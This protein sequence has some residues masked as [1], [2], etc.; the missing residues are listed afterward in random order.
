M[1]VRGAL[2]ERATRVVAEHEPHAGRVPAVEVRRHG[3]VGVAPQ[4]HVVVAGAPAERDRVVES[5]GRSLMRGPVAAAVDDEERFA[6]VGQRDQERVVSPDPLEREVH[7]RLA[8]AERG[9]DRAVGVDARGLGREVT[10]APRPDGD[11]RLVDDA[12]EPPDRVGVEPAAEVA[13]GGRVG[14]RLGAEHV[15]ERGVVAADL[16]VVEHVPAAKRVVRDV[17]DV[18]GVPVWA[19]PLEDP[20]LR[21]D[22]LGQPDAANQIVHG[23]EATARHRANTLGQ[24]VLG[25]R[26]VELRRARPLRLL[27]AHQRREP[28]ADLPLLSVELTSYVC[29]HLKGSPG[30]E[31]LAS[32]PH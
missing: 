21:V 23:R 12:Q 7:P 5:R 8:L 24:L 27:A 4:Q 11:A 18:V 14:D 19:R 30:V 22:R 6:R 17:E 25:A 1:D 16:D 26:R 28:R 9:H 20:E 10:L 31:W 2:D 3:E 32:Q 15:E 29:F 13:G